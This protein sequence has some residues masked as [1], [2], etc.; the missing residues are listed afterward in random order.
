MHPRLISKKTHVRRKLTLLLRA[1]MCTQPIHSMPSL[2]RASALENKRIQN[3]FP[4]SCIH[5]P[6]QN[7]DAACVQNVLAVATV[8]S[9]SEKAL[10]FWYQINILTPRTHDMHRHA[11]H[12]LRKHAYTHAFTHAHQHARTHLR[13]HTNTNKHTAK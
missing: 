12:A 4:T 13:A 11:P 5:K 8:A 9:I 1:P 3:A 10:S 2:C 6:F 7:I